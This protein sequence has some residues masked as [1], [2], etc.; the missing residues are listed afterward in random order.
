MSFQASCCTGSGTGHAPSHT[1]NVFPE[2]DQLQQ[3]RTLP[4]F[5][6]DNFHPNFHPSLISSCLP[7]SSSPTF[8]SVGVSPTAVGTA[9]HRASSQGVLEVTHLR[10][11]TPP[12]QASE[13]SGPRHMLFSTKS[14]EFLLGGK[15]FNIIPFVGRVITVSCCKQ[16]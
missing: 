14:F 13:D 11:D 16:G 5:K 3:V 4:M 6:L 8:T 9:G 7:V 1:Q 12:P 2:Y 15:C 10:G